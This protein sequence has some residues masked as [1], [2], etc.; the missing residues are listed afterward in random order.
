MAGSLYASD[1]FPTPSGDMP[2][3]GLTGETFAGIDLTNQ[4]TLDIARIIATGSIFN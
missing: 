2:D 4:S 3:P 1:M